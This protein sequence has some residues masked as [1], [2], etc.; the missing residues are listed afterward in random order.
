MYSD[1]E[2]PAWRNPQT[3]DALQGKQL[4]QSYLFYIK[5]PQITILLILLLFFYGI[6]I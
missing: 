6:D 1:N 2:L 5:L 4:K 3:L